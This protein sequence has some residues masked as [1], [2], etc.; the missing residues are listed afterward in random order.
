MREAWYP[1]VQ[2][3][4]HLVEVRQSDY[5]S[6]FG[7]VA[8]GF[9]CNHAPNSP[10]RLHYVLPDGSGEPRFAQLARM[11]VRY[12]TIYCYQA[13][14]RKD[15]G[16]IDRNELFMQA[17]DLFRQVDSSGQV[18]ELLVYF[19][20]EAVLKAPQALKKMQ[21]TTNAKEERKGSDGVHLRFDSSSQML[22]VIFA[23]AKIWGS[24]TGALADAFKS[25]ETFHDSRT[26]SHE[27][28]CFTANFCVLSPELQ[29]QVISYVDGENASRSRLVHACLIG[30][31]W[32]EYKCLDDERRA[33]FV[34][35]F[36]DRYRK[37]VEGFAIGHIN[38]KAR[39][40]KHKQVRFEFFILPFKDVAQ[41]R[42]WFLA[43]LQG[44]G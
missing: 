39:E 7:D 26:K 38:D 19:L 23:E 10:V 30:F 32:D 16:E 29:E 4:L 5:D 15:L 1:R 8:H 22:E 14:R 31:D 11:L 37:W 41:F 27:V 17:R 6:H 28:N 12:I 36:E 34:A 9:V 21:L 25:M 35:E 20:L 40:F 24:F 3:L 42:S 44:K 43:E 33:A 13:T 18:G 2:E